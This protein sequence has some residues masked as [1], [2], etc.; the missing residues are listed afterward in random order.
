[1]R[2]FSSR[3]CLPARGFDFWG[4]KI[5]RMEEKNKRARPFVRASWKPRCQLTVA[6]PPGPGMTDPRRR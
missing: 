5:I 2:R 4:G 6:A 3:F 1:M